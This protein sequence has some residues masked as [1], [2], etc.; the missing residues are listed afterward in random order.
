MEINWRLQVT[1]TSYMKLL[2]S[3][4]IH[5]RP[6]IE[7]HCIYSLCIHCSSLH[8]HGWIQIL[9]HQR[10][11]MVVLEDC[12]PPHHFVQSLLTSGCEGCSYSRGHLRYRQIIQYHKLLI[13]P[14]FHFVQDTGSYLLTVATNR[15]SK[16]MVEHICT[17]SLNWFERGL[18]DQ[19]LV[20]D[21][22]HIKGLKKKG[23]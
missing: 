19:T 11:K 15:A 10:E 17:N 8:N 3:I 1:Y 23:Y 21:A 2:I 16:H 12:Q 20:L 4:I 22:I 13:N 9:V 18:S 14:P 5:H 6:A 7:W